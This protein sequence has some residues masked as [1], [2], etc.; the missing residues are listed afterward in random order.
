MEHNVTAAMPT[1]AVS[2]SI[3]ASSHD[4][5]GAT[6]SSSQEVV[7][8]PAAAVAPPEVIELSTEMDD[9][10]DDDMDAYSPTHFTMGVLEA[11]C[12]AMTEEGAGSAVVVQPPAALMH[13]HHHAFDLGNVQGPQA[14]QPKQ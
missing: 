14:L 6:S 11:P 1:A 8:R 3:V 5:G 10:L 2:T 7:G 9:A 13:H 12:A 4:S